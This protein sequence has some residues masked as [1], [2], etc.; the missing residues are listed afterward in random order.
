MLNAKRLV[1]DLGIQSDGDE[2]CSD[3]EGLITAIRHHKGLLIASIVWLVCIAA[4]LF[5]AAMRQTSLL[6]LWPYA[7]ISA[8][9]ALLGIALWPVMRREWAQILIILA[10]LAL[11]IVAC[12]SIAFVPMAILFLCAP[13]AAMLFE[14]EKVIEAMVLAAVFAALLFYAGQNGYLPDEL[15]ASDLQTQWGRNAGIATT[16]AFLVAAMYAGAAGRGPT[17]T[18]VVTVAETSERWMDRVPGGLLK[19]DRH[20][21]VTGMSESARQLLR[22]DRN[23]EGLSAGKLFDDSDERKAF[24]Q[25]LESTRRSGDAERRAFRIDADGTTSNFLEIS[26]S[27]DTDGSVWVQASDQSEAFERLELHRV[28]REQAE[29]DAESRTL[30][31]A[32]VSHELRTPLN[33][34]IGFSDM[35]RSR[36]FGPL[37]GK[38]AEYADLIHQSGQHMLDLIGDVLDLSKVEA[39]KYE[40]V[41]NSFDAADVIRSTIKMIRPLADS[42]E[43]QIDTDIEAVDGDLILEADRKAVRQILLNLLSNAIKFTPKGGS[44]KVLARVT[45]DVLNISVRDTGRGMSAEELSRVGKPFTQG[46]SGIESENRGSGLGLSLVKSLVELHAGRFS[47]ASQADKGTTADVYLPLERRDVED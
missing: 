45:G 24:L 44:V 7:A 10:W 5:A 41:Y 16:I 29:Q 31:F 17:E 25:L 13:A 33:A 40:L 43:V 18:T 3:L 14:R 12:L 22:P 46:E 23:Y 28:A 27:A 37:P 42:A 9:P 6:E 15:A 19:I 38:Y 34:I 20:N 2:L 39:G 47:L 4:A 30:F 35:M 36:L 11:A 32:G 1:F 8:V 26:A 21:Q